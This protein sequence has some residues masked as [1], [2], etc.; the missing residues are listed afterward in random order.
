MGA[1]LIL[2]F[3]GY[4]ERERRTERERDN[5]GYFHLDEV[6]LCGLTDKQLARKSEIAFW[7]N[8]GS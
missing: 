4:E 1:H 7:E 6:I 3:P 2:A 5:R 8:Q